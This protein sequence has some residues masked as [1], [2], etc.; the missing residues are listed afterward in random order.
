[1]RVVWSIVVAALAAALLVA[2]AVGAEPGARLVKD[3][4]PSGGSDP[5]LMTRVGSVAFFTASDGSHGRELWRTDGTTRG[6]RL[7][8][9][10]RT[11]LAG[12]TPTSLARVGKQLFFTADDGVHGRELWVSDGTR[13]GTRMVRDLTPGRKG[14]GD[15]VIVDLGGRAVFSQG[16]RD[17][18][19]SDGSASGTLLLRRFGG[20]DLADTARLRKALYF[21]ADGAI[22]RTDG[23]APGT[24]S[25]VAVGTPPASGLTT[26][27]SRL[28]FSDFGFPTAV[29]RLWWSDGTADGTRRSAGVYA[30]TDLTVLD[31]ALYFDAATSRT[32]HPRL[33]RSDGSIAGTVPVQPRVRPLRGMVKAV[34]RLWSTASSQALPWRD[35]LWVSDGSAAGTSRAY[36]G[37]ADWFTSDDAPLALVGK[38]GRTWFAAGPGA[39]VGDTW[40][41]TDHELW[42]SDG[43]EGG[44]VQVTD[45][46]ASGS[47]DPRGLLSLGQAI[48]FGASDGAVGRE[49]W[50]V[51]VD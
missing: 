4:N 46:N 41:L 8:K 23:T 33:F 17:L 45:I 47:S 32:G 7:V 38:S 43:T 19:R 21:P 13:A 2:P 16:S 51:D 9:D 22:W 1:M 20:L 39:K 48:L 25:V 6:T 24:R 3:I 10:L 35:E 42:S 34:G 31:G 5:R 37:S 18:W 12:S 28:Y 44:T 29:P 15:L 50:A 11:G 36:G 26:F 27:K 40:T 14:S 30:P 49:L